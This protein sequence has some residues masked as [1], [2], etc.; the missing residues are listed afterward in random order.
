MREYAGDC[1]P[2]IACIEF[3][4]NVPL[5][6]IAQSPEPHNLPWARQD[7]GKPSAMPHPPRRSA[8]FARATTASNLNEAR[9]ATVY[10]DIH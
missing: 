5:C 7:G 4:E 1:Q 8:V 10:S 2:S 3:C 6:E 9:N